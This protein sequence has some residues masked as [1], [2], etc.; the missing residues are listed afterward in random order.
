MLGKSI[1]R[2]WLIC[3]CLASLTLVG[4]FHV[5]DEDWLP[6][7]NKLDTW[8]IHQDEEIEQALN[9]FISWVN[10]I[11]SEWDEMKHEEN[12][13]IIELTEWWNIETK[14]IDNESQESDISDE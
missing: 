3:L 9:S 1:K 13:E 10:M 11:S 5:P 6:N 12:G 4:C 7:R 14:N 8:D 2:I